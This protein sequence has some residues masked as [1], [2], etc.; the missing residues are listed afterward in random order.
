MVYFV[1]AFYI[2]LKSIVETMLEE[3]KTVQESFC[4]MAFGYI[5]ILS[6]INLP[7]SCH[8][9][10]VI[11][12]VSNLFF[13]II[14]KLIIRYSQ[15]ATEAFIKSTWQSQNKFTG[16]LCLPHYRLEIF[17]VKNTRK[18]SIYVASQVTQIEESDI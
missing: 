2:I 1:Q 10:D 13:P 8:F 4:S 12:S 11:S 6:K 3:A 16:V 15:N 9:F 14:V 7:Q 5:C 17:A 18:D